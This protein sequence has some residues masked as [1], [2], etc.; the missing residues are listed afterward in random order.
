MLGE[1]YTLSLVFIGD[2]KSHSLNKKYRGKDKPTNVLAFPLSDEEGEIFI[3]LDQVKREASSFEMNGS[4]F[5]AF[6]FIHGLLHL[7]GYPHGSRMEQ[8]EKKLLKEFHFC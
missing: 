3:N 7:E 5:C 1:K 2:K 8:A 6:L 4:S